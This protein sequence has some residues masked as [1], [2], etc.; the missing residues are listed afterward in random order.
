MQLV[1]G[2]RKAKTWNQKVEKN[3]RRQHFKSCPTGPSRHQRG[4]CPLTGR[5][6][7]GTLQGVGV[8]LNY[9]I[10]EAFQNLNFMILRIEIG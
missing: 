8:G 1:Q 6:G 2:T 3:K 4:K 9:M 5:A 10:F 7:E